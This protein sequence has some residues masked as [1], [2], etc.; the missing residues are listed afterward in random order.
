[1]P[2]DGTSVLLTV[3]AANV[4]LTKGTAG[5]L[6]GHLLT[7]LTLVPY[8]SLEL[9]PS[10]WM[11]TFGAANGV[12]DCCNLVSTPVFVVAWIDVGGAILRLCADATAGSTRWP[13]LLEFTGWSGA[14]G[15]V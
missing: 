13:T 8:V 12:D 6:T 11:L 10:V 5:W 14:R 15:F 1:M 4:L 9:N 2:V 3:D 7:A